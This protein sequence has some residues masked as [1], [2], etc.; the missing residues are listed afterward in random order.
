VPRREVYQFEQC[1]VGYTR[2][3]GGMVKRGMGCMLMDM[4]E[5]MLWSIIVVVTDLLDQQG[6]LVFESFY[7]LLMSASSIGAGDVVVTAD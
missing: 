5:M 4:S 1:N 2:W 6:K 3:V 7:S